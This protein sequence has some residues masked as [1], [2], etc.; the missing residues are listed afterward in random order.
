MYAPTLTPR[1]RYVVE[2]CTQ[3]LTQVDIELTQDQAHFEAFSGIKW[4]YG[5]VID[6][7]LCIY[8]DGLLFETKLTPKTW[9]CEGEELFQHK[10]VCGEYQVPI[11]FFSIIF[12]LISRYEEYLPQELDNDDRIPA[13]QQLLVQHQLHQK[14]IVHYYWQQLLDYSTQFF[15]S[16]VS[17][18][19]PTYQ[20][21]LTFDIDEPFAYKHKSWMLTGLSFLRDMGKRDWKAVLER[22]QT[23]Q[24]KRKDKY[25]TFEYIH[26]Q[27]QQKPQ[28]VTW[29]VLN[30]EQHPKDSKHNIQQPHYQKILHN[31]KA[32]YAIGI[33][34]SYLAA[35]REAIFS[36]QFQ[37][38][39][40]MPYMESY[41]KQKLLQE[42][43][44]LTKQLQQPI[45]QS[46]QHYLRIQ[47]PAT[48]EQLIEV[49]I[50]HDY[51]LGYVETI[52]FRSGVAVP[53]PF[54]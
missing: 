49:D 22:Y 13:T 7:A 19:Y 9:Y 4:S 42:I 1:L 37:A 54:F 25:D 17:V 40:I 48:Y 41:P 35:R 3:Y 31:L 46:R 45:T 18:T 23:L 21:H 16:N 8:S 53:Y 30:S 11:D 43:K 2:V 15:G 51:S 52:G 24:G 26:A 50:T 27:L 33:H 44:T 29:F 39:S 12:Y 6:E 5:Q 14:P 34:P 32:N 28:K 20:T 38:D 36:N 10:C 47:F